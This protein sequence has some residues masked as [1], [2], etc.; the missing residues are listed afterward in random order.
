MGDIVALF[1]CKFDGFK[2]LSI[3]LKKDFEYGFLDGLLQLA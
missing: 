2:K 3:V 1:G